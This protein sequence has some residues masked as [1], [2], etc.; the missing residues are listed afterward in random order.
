LEGA[1]R[2]LFI[3]QPPGGRHGLRR[4]WH[5]DHKPY[6][7]TEALWAAKDAVVCPKL[8]SFGQH[9]RQM[10]FEVTIAFADEQILLT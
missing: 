5:S 2:S 1:I 6:G 8:G 9:L 7:L 10:P 3:H 4:L